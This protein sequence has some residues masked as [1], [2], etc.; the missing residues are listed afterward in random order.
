MEPEDPTLT[1]ALSTLLDDIAA[2]NARVGA[3][4]RVASAAPIGRALAC[5]V[6]KL[7][8]ARHWTG[9]ALAVACADE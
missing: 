6:T 7:D 1:D 9:D 4:R 3:L 8:E 2:L 5:V